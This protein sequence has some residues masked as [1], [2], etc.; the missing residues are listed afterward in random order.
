M[1][2]VLFVLAL[3]KI[4]LYAAISVGS[5]SVMTNIHLPFFTSLS[6]FK[7][8]IFLRAAVNHQSPIANHESPMIEWYCA[9]M[10]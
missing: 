5:T 1:L 10:R 6:R 2:V 4:A 3:D 8:L 7:M 9:T